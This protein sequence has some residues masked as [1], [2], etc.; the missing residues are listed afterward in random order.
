[1]PVLA[2]YHAN[3]ML[4]AVRLVQI[5]GPELLAQCIEGLLAGWPERYLC[6]IAVLV[7]VLVLTTFLFMLS[8]FLVWLVPGS[9][10]IPQ[11]KFCCFM[12]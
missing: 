4:C 7:Q 5:A 9:A 1:V 12:R 8:C 6:L 10:A 2:E 11:K 3:L